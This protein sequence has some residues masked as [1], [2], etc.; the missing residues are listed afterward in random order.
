[1]GQARQSRSVAVFIT[2]R[3]TGRIRRFPELLKTLVFRQAGPAQPAS[4]GTPH[5]QPVKWDSP[6]PLE[7]REH[8]HA[9]AAE[10]EARDRF[11]QALLQRDDPYL[12]LELLCALAPRS[13]GVGAG[14]LIQEASWLGIVKANEP[15]PAPAA[16]PT[17]TSAVATPASWIPN[18][19]QLAVGFGAGAVVAL[20]LSMQVRQGRRAKG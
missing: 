20:L 18:W 16:P 19:R 17:A 6:A 14:Y 8:Y 10:A 3:R 4:G 12:N 13:T 5:G 7:L 2:A 11:A 15:R 1:M 9:I